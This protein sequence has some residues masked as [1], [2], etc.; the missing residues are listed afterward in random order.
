LHQD[1]ARPMTVGEPGGQQPPQ[2]RVLLQR[3]NDLV[4]DLVGLD[5]LPDLLR[6]LPRHHPPV[7]QC[8]HALENDRRR[9]D[10]A[11]NDRPHERAACPH[12]FPHPATP[13]TDPRKL[14]RRMIPEKRATST[15]GSS[16][17]P[18]LQARA[19][20]MP[21]MADTAIEGLQGAQPSL[22]WYSPKSD[23]PSRAEEAPSLPQ[24]AP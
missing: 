23:A 10:R 19:R 22:I 2:G 16:H 6:Q 7:L 3:G 4:V 8:P 20:G 13:G 1:L 11:E 14:R 24:P 21:S 18:V 15:K 12:Y 17:I 5:Q 9:G